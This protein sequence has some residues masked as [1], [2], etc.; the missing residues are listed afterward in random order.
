VPPA[1]YAELLTGVSR[2]S[3]SS[4]RLFLLCSAYTQSPARIDRREG[5]SFSLFDGSITGEFISL[6]PPTSIKQTFR[7]KEWRETDLSSVTITLSAPDRSTCRLQLVQTGVPEHD[8]FGNRD[9]HSKV[10]EGWRQFFFF[11]IQ[12]MLGYSKQ[13]V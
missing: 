4:S 8:R 10:E 9:V 5:G 2:R 11:R 7:F 12:N 13:P 3:L 1:S 6:T